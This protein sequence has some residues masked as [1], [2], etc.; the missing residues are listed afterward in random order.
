VELA[1]FVLS[2]I[3]VPVYE[4]LHAE[5]FLDRFY[6]NAEIVLLLGKF[7]EAL[8]LLSTLSPFSTVKDSSSC[9][10]V[11]PMTIFKAV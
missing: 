4:D 2:A 10:E 3:F 11:Y 6:K 8:T 1:A 7:E 9:I 5:A